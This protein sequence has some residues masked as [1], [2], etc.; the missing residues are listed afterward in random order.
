MWALGLGAVNKGR[1][2]EEEELVRYA[3]WEYGRTDGEWLVARARRE[4]RNGRKEGLRRWF[5]S[6]FITRTPSVGATSDDPIADH[7]SRTAN[8]GGVPIAEEVLIEDCAHDD[9]RSLGGGGN[10][11]YYRCQSCERV[12]ISQGGTLWE[13]RF[14][15]ER[16]P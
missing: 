4:G 12:V 15:G 11:I 1:S 7:G 8:D 9:L 2:R 10:A 13:L 16:R 6:L 14:K 5:R 3:R